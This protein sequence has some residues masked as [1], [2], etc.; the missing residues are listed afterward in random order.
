MYVLVRVLL[1]SAIVCLFVV[2]I[3]PMIENPALG[4]VL[5]ILFA[6]GMCVF[7][8]MIVVRHIGEFI[9]AMLIR[10]LESANTLKTASKV[11]SA[12][13]KNMA[14]ANRHDDCLPRSAVEVA[15]E[16]KNNSESVKK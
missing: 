15:P 3:Y 8:A 2:G 10:L 12:A 11:V 16:C 5:S 14:H 7:T 1:L 13:A 6:V 9:A 4:I